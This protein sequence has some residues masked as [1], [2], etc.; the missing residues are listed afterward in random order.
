MA[1]KKKILVVDDE[2][3]IRDMLQDYLTYN[4]LLVQTASNGKEALE[5]LDSFKPDAAVADIK[6]DIMDGI[7][8]SKQ[9]LSS[10]PDFPIVMITGY[11]QKYDTKEILSIGVKEIIEKPL[12][13]DNLLLILRKYLH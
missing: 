7:E 9:V 4:N 11:S 6:M 1:N 2:V 5:M 10:K 3:E 8:F 12:Q 13:L